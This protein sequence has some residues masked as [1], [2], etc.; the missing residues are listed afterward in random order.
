MSAVVYRNSELFRYGANYQFGV[1]PLGYRNTYDYQSKVNYRSGVDDPIFDSFTGADSETLVVNV[2]PVDTM[3]IAESTPSIG[4]QSLAAQGTVDSQ[5]FLESTV[6]TIGLNQTEVIAGAE[7]L[8]VQGT[9]ITS[10]DQSAGAELTAAVSFPLET[11]AATS[12]DTW[13]STTVTL[14]QSELAGA[15]E[16]LGAIAI[17][18]S[19]TFT[20][21]YGS[22][23][24][25]RSNFDYRNV[26]DYRYRFGYMDI[27][28]QN[29]YAYRM[30]GSYGEGLMSGLI[31]D[32]RPIEVDTGSALEDLDYSGGGNNRHTVQSED[33]FVELNITGPYGEVAQHLSHLAVNRY[34]STPSS[35]RRR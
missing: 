1:F 13:V 32:V 22:S 7:T 10:T 2:T 17:S 9:S 27:M 14:S 5:Q 33:I 29:D 24:Q 21:S 15:L 26:R 4:V 8:N 35:V 6:G 16:A 34:R 3:S 23:M 20:Y 11:D 30:D 19:D 31:I 28:Y 25:F 18:S 12:S